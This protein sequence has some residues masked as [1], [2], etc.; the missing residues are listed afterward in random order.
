MQGNENIY[1]IG[2][3]STRQCRIEDIVDVFCPTLT[4]PITQDTV[5]IACY[6]G[7]MRIPAQLPNQQQAGQ[8]IANIEPHLGGCAP[9]ASPVQPGAKGSGGGRGNNQC[10][11]VQVPRNSE[12]AV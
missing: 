5:I 11:Q 2:I 12:Y 6:A 9:V 1:L 8:P 10:V 4:V 7:C 3:F